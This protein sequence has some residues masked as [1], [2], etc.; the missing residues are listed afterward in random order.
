[1]QYKT[2]RLKVDAMVALTVHLGFV[3]D[4]GRQPGIACR[5]LCC[6]GSCTSAMS[7]YN[8]R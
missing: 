3:M 4:L 1:M 6:K 7:L 8:Y 2:P 5:Q